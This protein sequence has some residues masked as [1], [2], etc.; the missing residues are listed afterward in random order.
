[1][2][3]IA[4]VVHS[5]HSSQVCR[6]HFPFIVDA[7]YYDFNFF[8][9]APSCW[10]NTLTPRRYEHYIDNS[11]FNLFIG[12]YARFGDTRVNVTATPDVRASTAEIGR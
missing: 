9:L 4:H 12:V 8:L 11:N 10:N 7:I 5:R 3:R 6:S 2:C 1:M